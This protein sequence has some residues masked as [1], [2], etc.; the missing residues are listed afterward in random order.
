M[1]R[2]VRFVSQVVKCGAFVSWVTHWVTWL[3]Q[4]SLEYRRILKIS[5]ACLQSVQFSALDKRA[6]YI[7]EFTGYKH[8]ALCV[9]TIGRC[10]WEYCSSSLVWLSHLSSFNSLENPK[11]SLQGFAFRCYNLL[12]SFRCTGFG[13]AKINSCLVGF[14]LHEMLIKLI[15]LTAAAIAGFS[16]NLSLLPLIVAFFSGLA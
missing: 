10:R 6:S 3:M 9:T 8:G 1:L 7:K 12:N 14:H 4:N 5:F 13:R 2:N 11:I 16:I 15:F